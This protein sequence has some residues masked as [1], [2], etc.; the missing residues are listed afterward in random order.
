MIYLEEKTSA[1]SSLIENQFP[2]YVRENSQK[3]LSF[4]TSYYESLETKF[5]P[6]DIV[7]NLIDYYSI[8]HYRP[9]QLIASTKLKESELLVGETEVEVDSTDGFP[10]KDGYIR[11]L[12]LIHI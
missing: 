7:T 1:L 12:S 5:Q 6:L 10:E 2:Q 4:L 11:I 8:G 3:F 9:N